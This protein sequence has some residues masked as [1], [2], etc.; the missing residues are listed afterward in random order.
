MVGTGVMKNH[1]TRS[2]NMRAMGFTQGCISV[3]KVGT[4]RSTRDPR[5]GDHGLRRG[6]TS[7]NEGCGLGGTRKPAPFLIRHATQNTPF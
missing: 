6:H 7:V 1:V 2:R 4:P 5:K 3:T